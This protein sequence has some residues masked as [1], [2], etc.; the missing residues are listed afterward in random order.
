M[1]GGDYTGWQA[2]KVLSPNQGESKKAH[3]KIVCQ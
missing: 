1:L 3:F 2:V